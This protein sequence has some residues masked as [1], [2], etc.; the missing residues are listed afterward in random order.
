MLRFIVLFVICAFLSTLSSPL[1]AQTH[2]DES[3]RLIETDIAF[4]QAVALHGAEAW[5][6]FFAPNGSMLSDTNAPILG[7]EAIRKVMGPIFGDQHVSLRW[8]PTSAGILIPGN[9]GY[10]VGSYVRLWKDNEGKSWKAAGTY[11]TIWK[12][13]PDGTWKAVLDTGE[14]DGQPVE[15]K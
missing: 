2:Q 15:V 11:T 14:A 5:A 8:K 9:I 13:Q 12:K 1:L 3:A 10:T 4:D 6:S 7:H